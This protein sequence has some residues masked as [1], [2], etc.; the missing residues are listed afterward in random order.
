M[1]ANATTG[2]PLPLPATT[3]PT[4]RGC[5]IFAG[6][7]PEEDREWLARCH[8][9]TLSAGE[10]LVD[11]EDM[12]KDVFIV[13]TGEVRAVL[14]FSVGK[15]AILGSFKRGDI[16]GEQAAIDD[17]AR[18]ASLMAVSDATVT[19]IPC[20]VFLDILR[21][22]SDVA[23]ALLQLLSKRIRAM[24]DRL[25]ELSFL[26]TKHRLYNTL[27]RLSRVRN[28]GGRE[29]IISP[30]LVH[31]ELAEHIGASRETVS[32]EMS[33]LAREQLVERTS[34]A[35]VLKNP[36]ELSRRISRALEG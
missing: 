9:R 15:E 8:S 26:D 24:N 20:M 25:S 32:R 28:D 16:L 21:Q 13:Q 2:S 4:L 19:V 23:L 18:S 12:S 6:L 7:T 35:I 3:L 29:R 1:K 33:R 36:V 22:R 14:R 10:S 11:F 17:M 30:P 34:R 27:L 31:A 5:T